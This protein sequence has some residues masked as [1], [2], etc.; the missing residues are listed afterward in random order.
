MDKSINDLLNTNSRVIIPDF[1]AFIIKQKTPKI[2]VFNE[3][4]RYNDGLLIDYIAS[5]EK[6]DKDAAK[7]KITTFVEEANQ[8]LKKG[9]DI[10]FEGLGKLMKESSGKIAFVEEKDIGQDKKQSSEKKKTE[11]IKTT[12]STIEI[13]QKFEEKA[14]EKPVI[15]EQPKEKPIV[16]EKPKQDTSQSIIEEKKPVFSEQ[17][18]KKEDK[19]TV[20]V[21]KPQTETVT[22]GKPGTAQKPPEKH[23]AKGKDKSNT[24]QIVLWIFII[25]IIN[26]AI[27]VWFVYNDEVK[28]FFKKNKG[29]TEESISDTE[30]RTEDGTSGVQLDKEE[31]IAEQLNGIEEEPETSVLTSSQAGYAEKRYYI[32]AG[33]FRIESNADALVKELRRMGYKAEKFGKIGNLH[34]VSYASFFDKSVATKELKKIRNNEEPD[35][36]IVY[37]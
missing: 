35:A 15:E 33:C 3:F 27:I 34:A 24:L 31:Q 21:Q 18:K 32:V 6:I 20:T 5:S 11:D 8:K 16:G 36:W 10:F 28:S 9:E 13:E 4:L 22:F 17:T 19:V 7:E 1:G 23:V 2:V 37:H 25:L 14:K 29:K 30:E 26:G 12:K